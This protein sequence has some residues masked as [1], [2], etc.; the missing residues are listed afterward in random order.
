VF[1]EAVSNLFSSFFKVTA[2]NL[3]NMQLAASLPS[4]RRSEGI[5]VD[6]T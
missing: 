3:E 1:K 2:R 6:E 4:F 5:V